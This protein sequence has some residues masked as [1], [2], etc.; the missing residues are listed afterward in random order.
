MADVN[1]PNACNSRG[2]REQQ[3]NKVSQRGFCYHSPTLS[4]CHNST[5]MQQPTIHLCHINTTVVAFS[6]AYMIVLCVVFVCLYIELLWPGFVHVVYVVVYSTFITV[7]LASTETQLCFWDMFLAWNCHHR[8]IPLVER[9]FKFVVC[10]W[11]SLKIF[12]TEVCM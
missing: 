10:V 5:S 6:Y 11:Q 3:R 8:H 4:I 1:R 9:M 2:E 7:W 12:S